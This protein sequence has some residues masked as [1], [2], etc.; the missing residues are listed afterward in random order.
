V[1]TDSL[2]S[3]LLIVSLGGIALCSAG[4]IVLQF[5]AWQHLKPGIPK[6]GHKDSLFTKKADYYTEEGMRY[7]GM[8]KQ[9]IYA[10]AVFALLLLVSIELSGPPAAPPPAQP[11]S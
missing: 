2:A 9:L 11:A 1:D 10:M 7:V 8:Q 3:L 4:G 5:K 6:F